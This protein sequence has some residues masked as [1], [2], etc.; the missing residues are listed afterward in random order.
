MKR[1][2]VLSLLL[3]VAGPVTS[4]SAN[5]RTESTARDAAD[6]FYQTY[7][8]LNP[9]GLPTE[10]QMTALAPFLSRELI[11]AIATARQKQETFIHDHPDDKPP[12]IEGNLFASNDEGVSAYALGTPSVND[13]KASIPVYLEYR[14]GSSVV[15]WIDVIVL[16]HIGREW[17]VW[18]IF[19]TAPWPFRSGPNLRSILSVE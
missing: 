10:K 17:R 6:H 5:E 1:V 13:D 7:L 2:F 15:R 4:G 9:R 3:L 12:W 19:M 11:D 16:Q 18:D 8:K 14:E